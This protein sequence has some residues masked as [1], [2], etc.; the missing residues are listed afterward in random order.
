M[1]TGI[2]QWHF[3]LLKKK[4]IRSALQFYT[5]ND[6]W[7]RKSMRRSQKQVLQKHFKRSRLLQIIDETDLDWWIS[8]NFKINWSNKYYIE[9]EEVG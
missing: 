4:K 2:F 9:I 8:T 5:Y 6:Q 3:F 1:N 7:V